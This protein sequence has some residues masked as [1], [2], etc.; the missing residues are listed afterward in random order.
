LS[1]KRRSEPFR[2]Y[3]AD[4]RV[5]D[6]NLPRACYYNSMNARYA[7]GMALVFGA[8][9]PGYAKEVIFGT[10]ID[11]PP[12]S[13]PCLVIS[14]SE[15]YL[16][17]WGWFL[18]EEKISEACFRIPVKEKP[19]EAHI[20][21]HAYG[22]LYHLKLVPSLEV[23]E[24]G[25]LVAVVN[26]ISPRA[27]E[28]LG[29]D[30]APEL[31]W[32]AGERGLYPVGGIPGASAPFSGFIGALSQEGARLRIA[33]G[34][35]K[36]VTFGEIKLKLDGRD[37]QLPLI[38]FPSRESRLWLVVDTGGARGLLEVLVTVH[39]EREALGSLRIPVL[40]RGPTEKP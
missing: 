17:K 9:L 13:E 5:E 37:A 25:V 6:T 11:V 26:P 38:V 12:G 40:L 1:E 16:G 14:D 24:K 28:R 3:K 23:P 19:I 30:F 39:G 31:E 34:F 8:F 32:K 10:I 21:D 2:T 33:L 18:D 15:G 4:W 36:G 22:K 29:E 27:K 20:R 7:L 35:P